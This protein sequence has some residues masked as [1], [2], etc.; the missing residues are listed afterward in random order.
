MLEVPIGEAGSSLADGPARF[1]SGQQFLTN[2]GA[3]VKL[4]PIDTLTGRFIIINKTF[5][6]DVRI[7]HTIPNK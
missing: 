6:E 5:Q 1:F 2:D 7:K 4:T 3:R